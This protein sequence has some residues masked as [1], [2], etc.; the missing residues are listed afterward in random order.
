MSWY[1]ITLTTHQIAVGEKLRLREECSKL[2]IFSS[3]PNNLAMFGSKDDQIETYSLYLCIPND[4]I[5]VFNPMLES[6]N[7]VP[8]VPPKKGKV[9]LLLGHNDA[10]K[11][12]SH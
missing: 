7:A 3:S 2:F 6:N 5:A 12:L 4:S 11:L 8:C 1:K 9:V 10:V